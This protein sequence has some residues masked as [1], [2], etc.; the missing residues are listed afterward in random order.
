M[1]PDH[2]LPL[3]DV[4]YSL[5]ERVLAATLVAVMVA[6]AWQAV[7]AWRNPDALAGV[8]DTRADFTEGR[9]TLAL[10]KQ[11]DKHLPA[12][13]G[14]VAF[15]NGARYLLLR[16]TGDDVRAGRDGWLFLTEE[17]RYDAPTGEPLQTR[18]KLL[19][20]THAA[21]GERGVRLLVALVPDKARVHSDRLLQG[22]YP[23]YNAGRYRRA[24]EGL[25]SHG[26]EVVDLLTPFS[27]APGEDGPLYYRTDTHWNTRGAALAA[28][29][30]ARTAYPD[31]G[32]S[33]ATRYETRV[34]DKA[35]PYPGDLRRMIGLEHM[36][37]WFPP[38]SDME[39]PAVTTALESDDSAGGGL[40]GDSTVPVV[41]AG[42]SFSLRG[43]FH[44]ALE[45]AFGC[46]VLNTAQD[47]GGF[48]TSATQYFKDDAFLQST[49]AVVVWEVPE[50]FLTLK[51]D[52]EAGFLREAGLQP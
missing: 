30:I 8:P 11:M 35:R 12:R 15:A 44:G 22:E 49:P 10:E 31:G 7:A 33:P 48:L 45:Q 39:A 26:V 29:A 34:E 46:T 28:E 16:G 9:T 47:G 5:R 19:A 6:G 51:L 18:V 25:R 41:L 1:H 43:N 32:C 2:D 42:T 37:A 20:D 40:F 14:I 38:R 50:R 13:D 36:P 4:P 27:A 3:E 52:G 24:L 21:L 17:L 23:G